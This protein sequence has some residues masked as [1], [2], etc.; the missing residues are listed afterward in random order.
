M[1]NMFKRAIATASLCAF[2]ASMT[3]TMATAET[4]IDY[5]QYGMGGITLT[6]EEEEALLQEYSSHETE[7]V[8]HSRSTTLSS[9]DLSMSDYFPE[10]GDQEVGS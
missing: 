8:S 6:N 7:A 3:T 10:I 9:I 4:E 1:K 2:C 5:T